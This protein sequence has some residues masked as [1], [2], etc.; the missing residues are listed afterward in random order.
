[1]VTAAPKKKRKTRALQ[2]HPRDVDATKQRLVDAVGAILAKEGFTRLGINAI[3]KEAGADKALIYRYF[4]GL[5][6]LLEAYAESASFWPSVEEMAGG[7]LEAL[8][9]MPVVARWE[10]AVGHYVRQLRA[11]PLTQEILAWELSERNLV[12]ARLEEVRE[13][14]SLQLLPVLARG[15]PQEVDVAAVTALFGSAVHYLLLRARK[16]RVFNGIDLKTDDGW[17]RLEAA[18]RAM[19]TGALRGHGA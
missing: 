7:S 2:P 18:A 11:R 4:G 16:I 1:V 10:H 17:A 15:L 13:R 3:A 9:A 19:V 12:T 6:E 8:A 14:R 5:P